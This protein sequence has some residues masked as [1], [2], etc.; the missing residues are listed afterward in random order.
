MPIKLDKT[1]VPSL[2]ALTLIT[3]MVMSMV[4][5]IIPKATSMDFLPSLRSTE[6]VFTEL[7]SLIQDIAAITLSLITATGEEFKYYNLNLLIQNLYLN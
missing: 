4:D 6:V 2:T 1:I 3:V 5:H 7:A